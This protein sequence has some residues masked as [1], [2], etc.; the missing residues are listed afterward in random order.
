MPIDIREFR[1]DV[2][3][4]EILNAIRNE[5]GYDYQRRV[6]EA[7]QANVQDVIHNLM[8]NQPL[9]NE[10]I[11][12]LVNRIGLVLFKNN[13]WTNPLAKYKRGMLE[14]GDTIEE[15]MAGLLQAKNYDTDREELEKEIFGS[16]TPEVQAS[17][18]KVN[19]RDRYKLTIKEPLL[20]NA[21]LTNNGL[22]Q[23]I[24]ELMAMPTTS[25][26]WDEFLLMSNLFKEYYN[27]DGFYKVNVPDLSDVASDGPDSRFALRRIR[28]FAYRLPFISRQYNAAG[29]PVAATPDELE[30]FIT[31]EAQSAIDV[32]A[33]AAA[34][35]IEKANIPN[36]T[37]VIPAEHFGFDGVQAVLTSK[38][39]FVVADQR[40]ETTSAHNPA[41]LFN[42][43]WLHH[44]EVISASRFVP[45]ILFTTE[46]G[47]VITINPTPVESLAAIVIYDGN[48]VD[49]GTDVARGEL[50]V[51]TGDAVTNPANGVNIAVRYELIGALSPQTKL[52]QSGMLYVSPDDEARELIIRRVAVDNNTV[53]DETTI[54][55]TG[56]ILT[57][58]PNASVQTDVDDDGLIEVTPETLT[59]DDEDVVTIPTVVGV[60]YKKDGTNVANGSTHTITTETVFTAVARSGYELATGA[61]AS[62]TFGG[63]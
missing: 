35:N 60:Q 28:E 17:Y 33:L 18:H 2:S 44:W 26:Q 1:P 19:R 62:W 15:I 38:D 57:L 16:E 39:F 22:S 10:F 20:R 13:I 40:I 61:T 21:F 37:T 43:Y 49:V 27:N 48:S 47:D 7:T 55:V 24:T 31:P 25:D 41:A 14:Y 63:A 6:P 52:T 3:N 11:D 9:R 36:R 54:T 45:A 46:E 42:N 34:F 53:T 5:A 23:F 58:W 32:E 4:A 56:D 8:T 12:S 30:L 51:V 50:Y 59:M 29:L